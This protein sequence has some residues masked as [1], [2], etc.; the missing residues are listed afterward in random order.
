MSH[1]KSAT[2]ADADVPA[3]AATTSSTSSRASWFT[4]PAPLARV[5]RRFPL[6]TYPANEL[7]VR[8]PTHR[9]LPALYVFASDEDALRGWP[10]FNPSCLKWQTFLKLAGVQVRIVPSNNHASPTGALPFLIPPSAASDADSQLPVPSNKL[11]RYALQHGPNQ[12][13]DV[14]GTKMDAYQSLLDH[15]IRN[16]WLYALYLS[17]PNSQL[18]SQLYVAP[19]SSSK[20]VQTTVLYQLRRAAEAE[21]LQSV[22]A[23]VVDSAALYNG[24][25]QAFDALAT[26]LGSEAWFFGSSEPGLFDATVFAYTHLVLDETLAWIDTRMKAALQKFPTLVDHRARVL[27]RCWPEMAAGS[28]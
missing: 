12:V 4:I 13:P 21:I 18:L 14:A 7:P 17:P 9:H 26:A 25:E 24:A 27:A 16:A 28:V 2:G 22:G 10:S 5:F 20:P 6:V 1:Q 23:R 19:V 11:E 3:S 8:S 15:R